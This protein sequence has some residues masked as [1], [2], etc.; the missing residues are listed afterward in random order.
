[1]YNEQISDAND[2]SVYIIKRDG[3][4]V[5]F[6]PDKIRVAISKANKEEPRYDK[7]LSYEEIQNIVDTVATVI[8][9]AGRA[10]GVEEM[11][12]SLSAAISRLTI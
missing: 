5:E 10:M 4:Q 8:L 1:M 9:N 2:N 11:R 7:Q 3:R 12:R 6:S